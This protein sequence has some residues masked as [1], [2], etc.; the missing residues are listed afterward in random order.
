MIDTRALVTADGTLTMRPLKA[1]PS[2][3]GLNVG[4]TSGTLPSARKAG[5]ASTTHAP[6]ACATGASVRDALAGVA[7]STSPTPRKDSG[8]A[9]S[10]SRVSSPYSSS[11]AWERSE[12]RTLIR[13]ASIP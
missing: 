7:S 9:F 1:A 8:V 4:S 11:T 10:T 12:A 3:S 5:L 6:A 2:T 13:S